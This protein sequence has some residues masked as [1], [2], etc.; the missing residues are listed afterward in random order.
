MP[1]LYEI[2]LGHQFIFLI[3]ITRVVRNSFNS[4]CLVINNF[5]KKTIEFPRIPKRAPVRTL[6]TK[7]SRFVYN[8]KTF[9]LRNKFFCC[10]QKSG[11]LFNFLFGSKNSIS[12]I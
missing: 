11:V 8:D 10:S 5:A 7:K 6:V 9:L 12:T 3:L 1:R 2:G 4:D